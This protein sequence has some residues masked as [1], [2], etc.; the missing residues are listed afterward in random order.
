MTLAAISP[1]SDLTELIKF[2]LSFRRQRIK[3]AAHIIKLCSYKRC[4]QLLGRVTLRNLLPMFDHLRCLTFR[5][6]D[7]EL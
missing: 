1:L 4:E 2:N 5:F 6:I 3:M 7:Y